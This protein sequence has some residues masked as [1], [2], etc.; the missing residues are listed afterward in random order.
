MQKSISFRIKGLKNGE[1]EGEG[2]C[3]SERTASER[4]AVIK[5]KQK[6]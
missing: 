6:K 3:E 1:N 4:V 2:D 5:K